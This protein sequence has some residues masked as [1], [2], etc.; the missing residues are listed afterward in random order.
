MVELMM[1]AMIIGIL[2]AMAFALLSRMRSQAVESN[3]L[4]ALN[5]L[6]TAYEMY[7]FHNNEYPQWGPGEEFHSAKE[8]WDNLIEEQYLPSAYDKV[9]YDT[10]SRYFFGFTQDYAVEIPEYNNSDPL[11]GGRTSYFIIF[12]PYNFEKEALG[13]GFNPPTGWVAVRPRRGPE[14]GNYQ[15]YGLFVFGRD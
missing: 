8:I 1:V 11:R 13:I 10:S 14:G 2:S 12:H 7:Y 5:S 3:A 4:M 6:A 9:Q 15:T